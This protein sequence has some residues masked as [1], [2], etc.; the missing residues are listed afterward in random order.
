KTTLNAQNKRVANVPNVHQYVDQLP[1]ANGDL[2][3]L[4]NLR[5]NLVRDVPRTEWHGAEVIL[6]RVEAEME[7]R[8]PGITQALKDADQNYNAAKV[9]NDLSAR[10]AKVEARK[11]G[12]VGSNIQ[13]MANQLLLNQRATRFMKEDELVALKQL[14]QG[15][16]TQNV[17]SKAGKFLTN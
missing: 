12:T 6:P 3:D 2:A 11:T 7:T 16:A 5:N 17:L 1:K 15:T 14:A 8:S 9:A 4:Y 10:L 13:N